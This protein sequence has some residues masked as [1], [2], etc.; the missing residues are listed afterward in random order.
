MELH[1]LEALF[2]MWAQCCFVRT[3]QG[4]KPG[5]KPPALGW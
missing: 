3:K 1:G 5:F 2:G 4:C